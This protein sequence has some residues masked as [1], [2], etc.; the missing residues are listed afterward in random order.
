M[1]LP[2]RLKKTVISTAKT[3]AVGALL[4]LA[5]T[6]VYLHAWGKKLGGA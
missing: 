4:L 2:K 6:S 1:P 5:V 3:A